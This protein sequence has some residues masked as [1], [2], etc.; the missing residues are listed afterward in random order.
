VRLFRG[1]GRDHY[2]E[3]EDGWRVGFNQDGEYRSLY[4]T[5]F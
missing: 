1:E 3:S 2:S 5:A 4:S